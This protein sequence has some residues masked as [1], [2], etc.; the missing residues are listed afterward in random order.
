MMRRFFDWLWERVKA[1]D[2]PNC[3]Q[4]GS[5]DDCLNQF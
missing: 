5:C 1:P 2:C 3:G 4:R